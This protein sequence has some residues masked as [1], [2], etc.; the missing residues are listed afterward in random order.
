[1]SKPVV[2]VI[3]VL[4]AIVALFAV[5]V[6]AGVVGG[7]DE[8]SAKELTGGD[9]GDDDGPSF[10]DRIRDVAGG[11]ADADL[12]SLSADCPDLDADP[13]VLTF[14]GGCEITVTR[15]DERIR[16]VRLQ[17]NRALDVTAPAPEGDLDEL[18]SEVDPGKEITI[19]VGP[20]GAGDD[21]ADDPRDPIELVCV[22]IGTTCTVAVLNGR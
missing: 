19:P 11:A 9:G 12:A 10:V 5:G 20:N 14:S 21:T 13:P 16:L 22:G 4:V 6:G 7:D 1:M 3:V 2:V 17:G 8:P 15:S 18:E